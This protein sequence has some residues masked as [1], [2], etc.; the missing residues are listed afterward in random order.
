[1]IGKSTRI[2]IVASSVWLLGAYVVLYAI[3]I[4]NDEELIV[5]YLFFGAMPVV[6]WN[7]IRWIRKSPSKP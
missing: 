2:A 4:Y 5:A 3:D 1:M 7:G 6:V